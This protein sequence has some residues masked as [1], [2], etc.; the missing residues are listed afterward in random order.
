VTTPSAPAPCWHCGGTF[1]SAVSEFQPWYT[2]C[3]AGC[4]AEG[5]PRKTPAEALAAWN[6]RPREEEL[7]AEAERLR[8]ALVEIADN[9]RRLT[10]LPVCDIARRAL[11]DQPKDPA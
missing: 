7:A 5:P 6:T 10:N 2:A 4:L 11:G 1:V 9:G 8:A 3:C